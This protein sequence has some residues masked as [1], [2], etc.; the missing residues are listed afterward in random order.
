VPVPNRYFGIF[1]DKSVK[2]RGIEARR[3]DTAPFIANLQLN[4]FEHLAQVA[5]INQV[6][7]WLPDILS[8]IRRCLADLHNGRIPIEQLLIS[9]TL[10]RE[11]VAYKTPSP[12]ARAA[13]QLHRIGKLR[14][15]GQRIR[16]VYT[17]GIDGIYAWDLVDKVDKWHTDTQYYAKLILRATTSILQPF[18]IDKA[19]LH[20]LVLGQAWQQPLPLPLLK[21]PYAGLV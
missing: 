16:F 5:D 3:R 14:H 18:G 17:L 19:I 6:D 13:M 4:I 20:A 9:Q 7:S 10:S 12:A 2:L 11:A 1:T 15:P 8:L 21:R